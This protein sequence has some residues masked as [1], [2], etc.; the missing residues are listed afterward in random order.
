[1]NI[2]WTHFNWCLQKFCVNPSVE[3]QN[4]CWSPYVI[5]KKKDFFYFQKIVQENILKDTV[6][7]ILH[8]FVQFVGEQKFL[9]FT[10]II[11]TFSTEKE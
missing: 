5:K 9:N 3:L 10:Q 1:M 8:I 6:Y 11:I 2:L 7:E 4:I